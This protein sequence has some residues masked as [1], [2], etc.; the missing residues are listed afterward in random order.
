ATG[1]VVATKKDIY[2]GTK[3]NFGN[4]AAGMYIIRV[5]S[6]DGKFRQQ[7]KVVKQQN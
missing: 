7:F 2:S 6:P 4:L 3:M 5:T 1:R